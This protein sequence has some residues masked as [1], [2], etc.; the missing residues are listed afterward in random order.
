MRDE[1]GEILQPQ[2]LRDFKKR[3]PQV[4]ESYQRLQNVCDISGP[5]EAKTKELI[6]VAI[7]AALRRHGGLI[8]HLDRAKALG[9]TDDELYHAI[10]LAL[11]LAGFPDTLAAFKIAKEHLGDQSAP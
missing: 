4:W 6:R 11:P 5:L 7:S 3:F 9:A 1:K 2:T 8:A 10:L